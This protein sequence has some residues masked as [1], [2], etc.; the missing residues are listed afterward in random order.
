MKR[1]KLTISISDDVLKGAR[2]KA[3]SLGLSL[4]RIIENALSYFA[5]PKVFCFTC[6]T[7]FESTQTNPCPKCGWYKCPNCGSCA[8][9]LSEESA[10]VAFYMKRTL[11]EIFSNPEV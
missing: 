6:G 8:C 2:E 3:A 7:K 9:S 4:S 11:I 10:R 1:R 5:K